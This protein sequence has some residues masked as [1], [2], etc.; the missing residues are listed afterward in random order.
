M[1]STHRLPLL[2]THW[3]PT[4]GTCWRSLPRPR[5]LGT[6]Y[7]HRRAFFKRKNTHFFMC[8]NRLCHFARSLLKG[9]PF[10]SR[11]WLGRRSLGNKMALYSL[12]LKGLRGKEYNANFSNSFFL[13]IIPN[14][15]ISRFHW[16]FFSHWLAWLWFTR[17][18]WRSWYSGYCA[19][20]QFLHWLTPQSE[21]AMQDTSL[22]RRTS[23][24][25]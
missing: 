12:A 18:F 21:M 11:T 22:V 4:G 15:F 19:T 1:W 20:Y 6:R 3:W 17:H 9:A 8:S 13:L 16:A 14:T 23:I 5:T 24:I 2:Q 10:L 7:D 25:K